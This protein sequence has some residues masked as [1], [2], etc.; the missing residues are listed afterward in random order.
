MQLIKALNFVS[1]K[2]IP[3]KNYNYTDYVVRLLNILGECQVKDEAILTATVLHDVIVQECATS[4]QLHQL[5]DSKT[6]FLVDEY[7]NL[8]YHKLNLKDGTNELKLLVSAINYHKLFNHRLDP[9]LY[10]YTKQNALGINEQMDMR[11]KSLMPTMK[12]D[13]NN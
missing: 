5:F 6:A 12:T 4:N 7:T 11:F 8:T 2:R 10:D 1:L 9:I 13:L 3:N